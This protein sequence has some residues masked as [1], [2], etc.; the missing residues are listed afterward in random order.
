MSSNQNSF[1]QTNTI[2][3]PRYGCAIAALYTAVAIPGAVPITHC[4]PGCVDKQHVGFSVANGMQG[5]GGAVVPSVNAS[6]KEI[7]F[8]GEKKLDG[9]I[10]STLNVHFS[11][12]NKK[13][14]LMLIDCFYEV[15]QVEYKLAN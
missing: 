1:E 7:V 3:K 5:R 15:Q 12:L 4:G 9:L 11:A 8:G 14:L 13:T 2:G 6:E 10:K